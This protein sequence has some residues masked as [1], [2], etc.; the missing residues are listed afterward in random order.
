MLAAMSMWIAPRVRGS[1]LALVAWLSLVA[2]CSSAGTFPDLGLGPADAGGDA[3]TGAGDARASG[4][5]AASTPDDATAAPDD[6][7]AAPDDATATP[8]DATA[9]PDDATAAPDDATAAPD[10]AEPTP[11]DAAPVEPDAEPTPRDAAPV[12][13]DAEPTPRDAE[14]TPRDAEPT[15]PDAQ[16]NAPDAQPTADAGAPAFRGFAPPSDVDTQFAHGQGLAI[17]DMDG[18][19]DL[20]VVLASSLD[21]TVYLYTNGGGGR[22]TRA[23]LAPAGTIVAM[24]VAVADLDGDGDLDVGVVGLFD[25]AFGFQ[26]PGEVG[27]LRNPARGGGA[28]AFT[29]LGGHVTWGARSVAAGDVD[30][31]GRVDLVVGAIE[32]SN[33]NGQAQ[34]SGVYVVA[35][36]ASGLGTPRVLDNTLRGTE[37]VELADV[38]GDGDLDVVASARLANRV[39]WLENTSSAGA[40]SFTTRTLATPLAPV[41]LA[42]GQLDA[43][44]TPEVAVATGDGL[45]VLDAGANVRAAW[46]ARTI[47]PA[48]AGDNARVAIADFDGDGARDLVLSQFTAGRVTAFLARGASSMAVPVSASFTGANWVEARDVDGDGAP[49]A[50]V[51]TY[52]HGGAGPGDRLSV[53]R[54]LR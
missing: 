30:R 31:D 46:T 50:V 9:A 49:D 10:D 19:A 36:G 23:A 8:D 33:A 38:D 15:A 11:R 5:D 28:W 24:D 32:L 2:A 1:T 40:L 53:F 45:L 4:D 12:E 22:F 25:R 18:D 34:A 7:T 20:D 21:D 44:A 17:V 35:S 27:W 41:G 51:S 29:S 16:P 26:S 3:T 43:D 6:A 37:A 48:A 47:D 39:A 14:P 42:V 13:P 54:A 52:N